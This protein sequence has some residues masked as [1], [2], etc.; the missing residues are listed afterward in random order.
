MSIVHDMRPMDLDKARAFL[1]TKGYR[2]DIENHQLTELFH[3]MPRPEQMLLRRALLTVSAA[4]LL[5]AQAEISAASTV[6]RM[7]SL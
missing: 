7:L 1:E 6:S 3:S 4:D 2:H 5:K